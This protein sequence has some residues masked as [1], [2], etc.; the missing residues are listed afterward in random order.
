M[1][2]TTSRMVSCVLEVLERLG[3]RAHLERVAIEHGRQCRLDEDVHLHRQVRHEGHAYLEV[4]QFVLEPARLVL[5]RNT[6]AGDADIADR[7]QRAG[8]AGLGVI[9]PARIRQRR[10][11]LGNVA[12]AVAARHPRAQRS[13]AA[14]SAPPRAAPGRA[15][16]ATRRP[17]WT[18]VRKASKPKASDCPSA[19]ITL[20]PWISAV[21]EKGLITTP[22]I[23]TVRPRVSPRILTA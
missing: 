23:V 2:S 10:D 12:P 18:L 11:A 22:S 15:A 17:R 8:L 14:R 20:S 5:D 6:A 4:S 3:A 16:S 19:D 13:A 9:L 7:E 1:S 21:T